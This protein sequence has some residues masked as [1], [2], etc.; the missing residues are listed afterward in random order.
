MNI[1]FSLNKVA[2]PH[3]SVGRLVKTLT[4]LDARYR[5]NRKMS[6]LTRAQLQDVGLSEADIDRETWN[7]IS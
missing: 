7:A 2:T 6:R 5:N 3:L 4:N 1:L